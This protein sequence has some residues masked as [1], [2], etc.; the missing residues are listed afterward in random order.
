MEYTT[1]G[2]GRSL[3]LLITALL[4]TAGYLFST[5]PGLAHP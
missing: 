4:F 3:L 2:T 5:L 1:M